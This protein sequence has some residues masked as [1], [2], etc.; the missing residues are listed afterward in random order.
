MKNGREKDK[1]WYKQVKLG[2][3][4]ESI[5]VGEGRKQGA[6]QL[7]INPHKLVSNF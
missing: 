3:K 2:L 7:E 4:K 5:A 1:I 6:K